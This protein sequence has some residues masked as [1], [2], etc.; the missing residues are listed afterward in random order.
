MSFTARTQGL[1]EAYS[2]AWFYHLEGQ[3][4]K[5]LRVET[6]KDCLGCQLGG[7]NLSPQLQDSAPLSPLIQ[8]P[9]SAQTQIQDW[10]QDCDRPGL[11]LLPWSYWRRLP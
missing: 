8:V 10:L 1:C 11:A 6:S 2:T 5:L 7:R 3:K 9:L 4:R